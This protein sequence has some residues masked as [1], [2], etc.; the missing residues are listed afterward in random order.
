MKRAAVLVAA[1]LFVVASSAG[2]GAKKEE[3]EAPPKPPKN[4]ALVKLISWAEGAP[5]SCQVDL[6]GSAPPARFT[7]RYADGGKDSTVDNS[8]EQLFGAGWS[9][10][11][12]SERGYGF[13][14]AG[15]F[16][17]LDLDVVEQLQCTCKSGKGEEQRQDT[18]IHVDVDWSTGAAPKVTGRTGDGKEATAVQPVTIDG[19]LAA[20]EFHFFGPAPKPYDGSCSSRFLA[21][22]VLD[23]P[24]E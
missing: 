1:F 21:L 13:E 12:R 23:Q 4:V 5:A 7:L 11:S 24:I 16:T 19:R 22:L 3:G 6:E 2:A 20:Y 14:K 18:L 17:K 8:T 10:V 15:A 9:V